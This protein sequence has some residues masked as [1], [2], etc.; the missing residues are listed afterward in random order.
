MDLRTK[1]ALEHWA[2]AGQELIGF[3]AENPEDHQAIIMRMQD[4]ADLFEAAASHC[5]GGSEGARVAAEY[6]RAAVLVAEGA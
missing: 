4:V 2:K 5:A 6:A 1:Q 3:V